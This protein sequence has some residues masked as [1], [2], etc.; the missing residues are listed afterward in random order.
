MI[1]RRHCSASTPAPGVAGRPAT[2]A[3]AGDVHGRHRE[4]VTLL[5]CAEARL[6]R[7]VDFVLQAGDFE[8]IRHADDLRTMAAPARYRQLGDFPAVWAGELAL[9]R[10]VYFI[11]GN[12]EP[13]GFLKQ[14][15]DGFTLCHNCT[16]LG[17]AFAGSIHGV[18]VCALSG[19]YHP[20]KFTEPLPPIDRR[21]QVSPKEY[22][23]FRESHVEF[24]LDQPGADVLVLHEWPAE[25]IA[26]S[27][28]AEFE[29]RRRSLRYDAVGNEWARLLI[30]HLR[31]A[32]VIAGH[33]HHP[34]RVTIRPAGNDADSGGT[35][36]AAL[37]KVGNG[38][39]ALAVF[40][41]DAAGGVREVPLEPPEIT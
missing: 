13:V 29:R 1:T 4:L 31:P 40:A 11:G 20:E 8:P 19:I 6:G 16:Y 5:R 25:V 38:P 2:F 32:L 14:H 27:D 3:C 39:G 41:L 12:H 28:A 17:R 37:N 18:R 9:P 35:L 10:P 21:R 24:L 36:F 30:A 7:S 33:L 34:Y 15:P 23:Y 22:S 26:E